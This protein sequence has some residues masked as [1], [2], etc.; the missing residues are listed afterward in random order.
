MAAEGFFP[1]QTGGVQAAPTTNDN[2]R[3]FT[4]VAKDG[5][6]NASTEA[7]Y[8]LIPISQLTA[9]PD[10][11]YQVWMHAKDA[12]G[13]W[14][15]WSPASFTIKR[16]LFA[17]GFEAGTLAAWTGG[18]VPAPPGARLSATAAA[19]NTGGFGLSVTG[20]LQASATVATPVISPAATGYHVRF[21][22]K[23]NGLGTYTQGGTA[24]QPTYTA[25]RTGIL[26]GMSGTA[27]AFQ[28]QYQRV[29]PTAPA[30]VRLFFPVTAA[31]TAWVTIGTSTWSSI[32]V[33]WATGTK[34]PLTITVNG[35]VSSLANRNTSAYQISSTRM[36]LLD[37]TRNVVGTAF[38]DNFLSS[39]NPLP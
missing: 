8:G 5:A 39:L 16:G 4:F 34:V 26:T 22:F 20:A 36:G 15:P 7:A 23:P 38:F 21:S 25:G 3:G 10:G 17:D 28:V 18:T 13:N 33:D 12:A 1:P 30:Q 2:G 6:F 27:E 35:A 9:Y 19:A 29:S 24:G 14:G 37:A 32:Q 11:T 31:A